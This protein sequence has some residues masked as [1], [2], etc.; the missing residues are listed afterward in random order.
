MSCGKNVQK[1][2][3]PL[4]RAEIGGVEVSRIS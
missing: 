4:E 3:S 1:N 2:P